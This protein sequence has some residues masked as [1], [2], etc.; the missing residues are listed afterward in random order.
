MHGGFPN[1]A[2]ED[3]PMAAPMIITARAPDPAWPIS[4][5]SRSAVLWIGPSWKQFL[6]GAELTSHVEA[7]LACPWGAIFVDTPDVSPQQFKQPPKA[8]HDLVVRHYVDDPGAD[9]LPPNRLP[10]FFLRGPK[11]TAGPSAVAD[12]RG[13][14][15]RLK[16]LERIPAGSDLFA[17][18]VRREEDVAG[19]I[20]ARAVCPQLRRV[21]VVSG[22]EIELKQ[23]ATDDTSVVV[24][25]AELSEFKNL[26]DTVSTFERDTAAASI[27]IRTPTGNRAIDLSAAIDAS[28]PITQAFELIPAREVLAERQA[29]LGD[30]ESFLANPSASWSAYALGIPL[31]RQRPYE[32]SLLRQLDSFKKEGPAASFTAWIPA[33]DGSG[34]TTVLRLLCFTLAR[35]GIPVLLAR[36]MVDRFDFSQ[37]NAFLAQAVARMG[38]EGVLTAETPWV[39][40]FDASHTQLHWDFVAGLC[41]GLKKVLR[42]T[43][44]V[45]VRPSALRSNE[46]R[47]RALGVN[48]QLGDALPNTISAD[49]AIQLGR[50]LSRFLPPQMAR[51]PA[52]WSRFIEN[53]VQT[54]IEGRRSL[55]WVALRFWLFRL[56]G[57]EQSMR[58][59]LGAKLRA[60]V[61][62]HAGC[63]PGLLEAAALSRHRLIAPAN[64]LTEESRRALLQLADDTHNALGFRYVPLGSTTGYAFAH[65]LI[66]EEALRIAIGEPELLRTV[67]KTECL[68]LADLELHLL[69]R[70]IARE[71]AATKGCIEI[72]EELV[73]SALRVDPREA[74]ANYDVRDRIVELLEGAPDALFDRSQIFN[75]HLAKARR[76]L[77]LAPPD[78]RW[79]LDTRIEQLELA[80]N[81]LLDALHNMVPEDDSRR[82]TPLNMWVSLALTYD[83]RCRLEDQAGHADLAARYEVKAAG[84]F[85]AAQKLDADNS[86]VLE[87]YAR[88][89]LRKARQ[90]EPGDER[91][92]LIVDA[93]ALLEWEQIVDEGAVRAEPILTELAA[94][95]ELLEAGSGTAML[96]AMGSKGSEVALLAL[97]HLALRRQDQS[98]ADAQA[99]EEAEQLL[100]RVSPDQATWRSH[101]A[102]YRI[103]S[104]LRPTDFRERLDLLRQLDASAEFAWPQQLRLEF[105]ILLI[106]LGSYRE[107]KE[108][109][110][111]I[112]EELRERS[113]W[114]AVP[115]EL[116]FLADPATQFRK[117]LR[118]TVTVKNVSNVGRNYYGIPA[119]WGNVDV[120]IRPFLF[121]RDVIRV[122]D[123]LDCV[124][125]FTNFG[126]QAVPPT[127]A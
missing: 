43:V 9:V 103:V 5:Q 54:S 116:K 72:I 96:M 18:G 79:T 55:F 71:A 58:S 28:H 127:A 123:E 70:L 111:R 25:R 20:E 35:E 1:A 46:V 102:L 77:A 16:M 84:A 26:L 112:R 73:T 61:D 92:R 48:R 122:R 109:F 68:N 124:I 23:L 67:S 39:L 52:E 86:Y 121:G 12:P 118:T 98:I 95:Y 27:L 37:L 126:P 89:M 62:E 53:T 66:A 117:P 57:A 11:G 99:L 41:N 78:P 10:V 107:G 81:H 65:P 100:R 105:G 63:T 51:S 113:G 76:H 34:A 17:I 42:S 6:A 21:I 125:Q 59:W 87:N 19:L 85:A 88:F 38:E 97:A 33:E 80:E 119:G 40:A 82:E 31:P 60:A 56:P 74:P 49:E 4:I 7:L 93:I 115:R 104:K 2:A 32:D 83:A 22:S 29:S 36:P 24:W 15:N 64:L 14:L 8:P 50:H 45:A 91:T 94:A 101:A 106:Q 69:G 44:V 30:V 90:L 108:V 120:V 110:Q 114:L 75:H 3:A 13:F 47:Q